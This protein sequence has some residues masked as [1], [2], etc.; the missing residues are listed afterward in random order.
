[1]DISGQNENTRLINSDE[2]ADSKKEQPTQSCF[3]WIVTLLSAIGGLLFG[4]DTG[5]ISG[6]MLL[7]RKDFDLGRQQQEMVVA[8]AIGGAIGGAVISSVM[9]SNMGRK[10]TII[11]SSF[12]FLCG[13]IILAV[14]MM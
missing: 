9:T 10:A 12:I 4:Y 13:A 11:I 14:Y 7:I 5:I 1:M 3:T 2:A 8:S 6:A